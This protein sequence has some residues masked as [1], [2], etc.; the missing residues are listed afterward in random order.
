M[1]PKFSSAGTAVLLAVAFLGC[2]KGDRNLRNWP[3]R[4]PGSMAKFEGVCKI[5][6]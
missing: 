1:K 4:G 2:G 5:I 6:I 3:R